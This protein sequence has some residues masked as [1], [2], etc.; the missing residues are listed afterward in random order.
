[1][2]SPWLGVDFLNRL[3]LKLDVGR[4]LLINRNE[5]SILAGGN[6]SEEGHALGETSAP[7]DHDEFPFPPGI[8]YTW[9]AKCQNNTDLS[10]L[11]ENLATYV[12]VRRGKL[13]LLC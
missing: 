11:T 5:S 10:D 3:N 6:S 4:Q 2:D 8:K 1:M 9:M 13:S 7:R 12:P